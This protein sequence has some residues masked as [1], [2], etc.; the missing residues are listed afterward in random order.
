[1]GAHL[2]AGGVDVTAIARGERL[3]SLLS[4]GWQC[5]EAGRTLRSSAKA[6]SSQEIGQTY[7]VVVIAIKSNSLADCADEIASLCRPDT[8]VLP[9]LNGV[10]WWMASELSISRQHDRIRG[11]LPLSR[12]L[13]SAVYVT[14]R[15]EADGMVR[16]SSHGRIV[17]GE[18]DGQN[19]PRLR[20]VT[21]LLQSAGLPVQESENI[22]G[23]IWDKLTGNLIFNPLSAIT[24]STTDCLVDSAFLRPFV[25]GLLSES[26]QIAQ[27]LQLQT[28]VSLDSLLTAIASFGVFKTSMLQDVEN[29]R[30]LEIESILDS[31]RKIAKLFGIETPYIDQLYGLVTLLD[32][33]L[34]GEACS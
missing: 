14:A 26:L 34:Q 23:D 1:V 13:G 20:L 4:R 8:I 28:K 33:G 16:T 19:T 5:Q 11:L 17:L 9:M 24:R 22:R 10:P 30:R 6:I 2:S 7:D 3:Q 25:A 18:P 27:A 32:S 12:I 21:E 31:P 15:L 29:G